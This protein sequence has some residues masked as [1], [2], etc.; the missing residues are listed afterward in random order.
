[1]KKCN[2]ELMKELKTIQSEI[3][4]LNSNVENY[5]VVSYFEGEEV[6]KDFD[7]NETMSKLDTLR[8]EELRI[9]TLL[10]YSNATT[11]L[12]AYDEKT[13]IAEG[14][15]KLA[16]LTKKLQLISKLVRKK[17]VVK[18]IVPANYSDQADRVKITECLYDIDTIPTIIK[19][20]K[21]EISRLQVAIDRTNLNNMI[22]C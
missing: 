21:E 6:Y 4:E 15:V 3:S 18:T 11:K 1:M 2:A 13:T 7:F 20:L 8:E 17:K 5:S 14:L 19:E 16:Q 12:I 10:A 9:K 22:D